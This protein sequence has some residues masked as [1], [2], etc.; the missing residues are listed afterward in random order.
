MVALLFSSSIRG[1]MIENIQDF[2]VMC[3]LLLFELQY[4]VYDVCSSSFSGTNTISF[5]NAYFRD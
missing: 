3:N 4:A 1:G 5:P 2:N